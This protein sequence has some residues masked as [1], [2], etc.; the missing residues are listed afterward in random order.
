[1]RRPRRLLSRICACAP[2]FHLSLSADAVRLSTGSLRSVSGWPPG[3][4]I[5][6]RAASVHRARLCSCRSSL[7]SALP[8]APPLDRRAAR[9]GR[10]DASRSAAAVA[11]NGPV[12]RRHWRPRAFTAASFRPAFFQCRRSGH[13]LRRSEV[14]CAIAASSSSGWSRVPVSSPRPARRHRRAEILRLR[15]L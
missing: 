6:L 12:R 10:V 7:I 2:A 3:Q 8:A 11:H 9:H 15:A 4:C 1:M 5:A 13:L 14:A